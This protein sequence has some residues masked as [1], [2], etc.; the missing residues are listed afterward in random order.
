MK[1]KTYKVAKIYYTLIIVLLFFTYIFNV[2]APH[3]QEV[4]ILLNNK[5]DSKL[6]ENRKF[7]DFTHAY[8]PEVTEHMSAPRSG[9]LALWSNKTELGRPLGQISGLSGAYLPSWTLGFLT[10]DPWRFIS[11]LSLAY[12]FLAGLFF[13]L[14]AREIGLKPEAGLIAATSLAASPALVYW[15]TFPLFPAIWC[16]ATGAL[17][18]A[19]RLAKRPD[20]LGWGV[21][22]FSGY[23]LLM[24]AYPQAV[25]FHA[26]ILGGYGIWLAFDRSRISVKAS[27]TFLVLCISALLVGI[28]M[29]LPA[30]FDLFVI[31]TESARRSVDPE[32]FTEVLPRIGSFSDLV[33]FGLLSTIPELFGNPAAQKYRFTYDGMSIMLVVVF[34]AGIA[35]LTSFCQTWGWWL[36]IVIIFMLAFFHPLYVFA[37]EYLGFSLSRSTPLVGAV[38]PMTII[39]AYGIDGLVRRSP[40]FAW[41]KIVCIN[42]GLV[43]AI[44]TT[45]VT[46]ALLGDYP[47]RWLRV[48]GM[49]VVCAFLLAQYRQTRLWLLLSALAVT[50]FT[51]SY[52][53]MLKQ[54]REE[55]ALSSPLV[56]KIRKNLPA[57]ARY[58]IVD[59]KI[60]AMM[61]NL[62][63]TLG[64]SSIHSYNSLS[65]TRYHGLIEGLGG[66][67]RQY[68]RY[69]GFIVPDYDDTLFWMSNIAVILSSEPLFHQNLAPLGEE[70]G[71]HLYRVKDRMGQSL[72]VPITPTD[73]TDQD[74]LII[75]SPKRF[76]LTPPRK[77]KDQGDVLEFE[78]STSTSSTLALSQKFH[79]DWHATALLDGDWQ[80]VQTV[81]VNEVF[82]GVLLPADVQG[83]RLEFKPVVRWAWIAHVFWVVLLGM[84]A[85][86]SANRLRNRTASRSQA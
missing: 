49:V 61:P 22:A 62:N 11:T 79:R 3:R 27:L 78:V 21:L 35:A 52:P 83:V 15:L 31:M 85:V 5:S 4:D 81:E 2:V 8:I 68:G 86:A 60:S 70:S 57:G 14:F 65:P 29:A 20:L 51:T 56:D 37:V 42:A 7:S 58:A 75:A 36:A 64:L 74:G 67:L 46:Y 71:I 82:L 13:L 55:I 30:Y 53:M 59:D 28:A 54:D 63:A 10:G 16:W 72:L 66:T 38:L 40:S 45:G 34:F 19:T 48:V 6:I 84:I 76:A 17:F 24:T 25:V 9:W 12:C 23:S 26:Y 50:L 1:I 77:T 47:I 69:N 18:A 44:V 41:S 33:S 43:L 32:F 80:P 73:D 39:A